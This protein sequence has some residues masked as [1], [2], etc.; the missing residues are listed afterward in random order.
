MTKDEILRELDII[1]GSRKQKT[2]KLK[3]RLDSVLGFLD[4]PKPSKDYDLIKALT[5]VVS[6]YA[7][8]LIEEKLEALN[9]TLIYISG[10]EE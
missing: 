6:A 8:I 9:K 2:V 3:D 7:L 5:G 10:K 4:D 1:S